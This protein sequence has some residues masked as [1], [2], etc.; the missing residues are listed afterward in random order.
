MAAI[1][2]QSGLMGKE[3]EQEHAE[4]NSLIAAAVVVACLTTG[5]FVADNGKQVG[6]IVIC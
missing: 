2:R 5:F 6:K 3:E 1:K 4:N